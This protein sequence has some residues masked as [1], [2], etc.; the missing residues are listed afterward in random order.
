MNGTTDTYEA[1]QKMTLR[2]SNNLGAEVQQLNPP[3]VINPGPGEGLKTWE[4]DLTSDGK[5]DIEL[6]VGDFVKNE[7]GFKNSFCFAWNDSVEFLS[8]LYTD[9][10]F[11]STNTQNPLIPPG[12]NRVY[13]NSFSGFDSFSNNDEIESIKDQFYVVPFN[14]GDEIDLG[15]ADLYWVKT[16]DF[17]GLVSARSGGTLSTTYEYVGRGFWHG[18]NDKYL[19]FRIR[20]G[21]EFRYGWILIS[22]T[23]YSKLEVFEYCYFN[24]IAYNTYL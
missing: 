21:Q 18:L 6:G 5:D 24:K 9:T 1:P 11:Y 8:A 17:S 10:F 23:E 3:L 15:N 14:K 20:K 13:Y 22:T 19:V 12:Y 2:K 4:I 16:S 7:G